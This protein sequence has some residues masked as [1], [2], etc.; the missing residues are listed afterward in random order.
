MVDARSWVA[1]A[2]VAVVDLGLDSASIV[3]V[4]EAAESDWH[5][6]AWPASGSKGVQRLEELIWN[7]VA[8]RSVLS[9]PSATLNTRSR[10]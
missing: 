4:V 8:E 9:S 7:Q 5:A 2:V 10:I 1:V 3:V 6:E